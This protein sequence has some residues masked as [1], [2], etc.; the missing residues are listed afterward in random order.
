MNNRRW[1]LNLNN[2]ITVK[3]PKE[4]TVFL[5]KIQLAFEQYS[6]PIG[7]LFFLRKS[8]FFKRKTV[9]PK[10]LVVLKFIQ[11]NFHVRYGFRQG[12][13]RTCRGKISVNSQ[14]NIK[15]L[16]DVT[17]SLYV[18]FIPSRSYRKLKLNRIILKTITNLRKIQLFVLK[19]RFPYKN[20]VFLK[21]NYD[22][23]RHFVFVYT[24]TVCSL[25]FL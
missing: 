18:I 21:E 1:K 12:K 19:I 11:F 22:F 7:K 2:F 13:I 23:L 17:T 24:K 25:G 3:N 10:F 9:I 20:I 14:R 4:T 5:L 8:V 16:C 6:F 15:L